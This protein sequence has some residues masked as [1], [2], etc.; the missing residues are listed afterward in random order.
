MKTILVI[1]DDKA[2]RDLIQELL[3]VEGFNV[4]AAESGHAG[5][6]L[7]QN[8]RPDLI[9]CDVQMPYMDG[10]NVLLSLQQN[11]STALIPFIFLTASGTREDLRRGMNLGADDYLV[12]P[13]IPEELISAIVSRLEKQTV[14]QT[15]TQKQ[16]DSLRTSIAM[17][18][19]HEFHT[20]LNG[21]LLYSEL[22]A[23]G[24]NTIERTEL[25][26]IATGIRTSA[27]RLYRLV[28]KFLRYAQLEIIAR[29]PE[30]LEI[31]K[32]NIT[33]YP[34]PLIQD[35]AIHLARNSRREADLHLNLE[36]A[37]I[38]IS[39]LKLQEL[40]EELIEN[41]FKFSRAGTT[42]QVSST[43]N[44]P[45][46]TICVTNTGRGMTA[47]QI[48]SLGAYMQFDRKIYEQQ[49]SGLGL[50]IAKRLTE[51]HGGSLMIESTPGEL[52]IVQAIL[53]LADP[54]VDTL[55]AA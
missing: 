39:D 6:E 31:L 49:G 7:A 21:I 24:Y 22:L 3:T 55:S 5:I 10:Y 4:L 53:P 46:F 17:S 19:P 13:C 27:D 41:A 2:I 42:V 12:K 28:Q 48:A 52:T 30:R 50:T 35:I 26:N 18:L 54:N 23:E 45:Q 11:P 36:N 44:S 51:L 40:I 33:H 34:A 38:R 25:A 9:L 32:K 8:H 15:Q 16:L 29:D 43:A 14:I 37:L 1:D 47:E 20:P